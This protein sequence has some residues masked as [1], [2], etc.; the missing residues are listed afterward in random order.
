[1]GHAGG[2]ARRI[3][4]ET[5]AERT[6]AARDFLMEGAGRRSV[7]AVRRG[8]VRARHAQVGPSAWEHV[9]VMLDDDHG[10][11][12]SVASLLLA[13]SGRFRA[14][15]FA[16]LPALNLGQQDSPLAAAS[17]SWRPYRGGVELTFE[18]EEEANIEEVVVVYRLRRNHLVADEAFL[19]DGLAQEYSVCRPDQDSESHSMS[20]AVLMDAEEELAARPAIPSGPDLEAE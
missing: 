12:E 4:S 13:E 15:T 5:E 3:G 2:D 7:Q 8:A 11:L 16:R 9:E 19:P 20:A 17:G 10:E 18:A 6:G 1:M 14:A